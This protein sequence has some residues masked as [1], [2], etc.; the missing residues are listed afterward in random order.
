[1]P[2]ILVLFFLTMNYYFKKFCSHFPLQPEEE[3][4]SI[5]DKLQRSEVGALMYCFWSPC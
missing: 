1:M 3:A 5:V 2:I 4:S